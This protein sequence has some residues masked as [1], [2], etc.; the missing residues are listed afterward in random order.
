MPAFVC[1]DSHCDCGNEDEHDK[2]KPAV[3]LV[4]VGEVGVKKVV[5]QEGG[6]GTKEDEDADEYVACRI[7]EIAD[8]I[9]FENGVQYFRVH[10]VN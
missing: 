8:E 1:P 9:A 4:E 3:E 2:G 7:G 10:G 5:R 6:D